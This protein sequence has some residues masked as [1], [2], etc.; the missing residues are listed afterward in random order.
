M[1]AEHAQDISGSGGM[2]GD[3][4]PAVL[5]VVAL[6]VDR[7]DALAEEGEPARE[8]GGR[9]GEGVNDDV[10]RRGVGGEAREPGGGLGCFARGAEV[11]FAAEARGG[12]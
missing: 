3:A 11:A 4:G 1:V 12:G 8:L 6:H 5:F 9:D 10:A 2:A 7:G